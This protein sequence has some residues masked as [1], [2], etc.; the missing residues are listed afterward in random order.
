MSVH[1]SQPSYGPTTLAIATIAVLAS[2][3]L[4]RSTI[5]P[6][7]A[8][9]AMSVALG[10]VITVSAVR[11]GGLETKDL[12][13]SSRSLDSGIRY[14]LAA[15]ALVALA[16][17]GTAMVPAGRDL[18]D[19]DDA[20]VS[21]GALALRVALIIPIGTVIV[22]ELIFRG[23]LHAL[24]SEALSPSRAWIAGSVFFGLWHVF[25]SWR[26]DG[27]LM[28]TAT[29]FATSVAGAVFIWLRVRSDSLIAPCIAHL[30]T[31]TVP[32]TVAWVL[33]R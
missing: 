17:A 24:L 10:L 23:V 8:H 2:V 9:F 32:L 1:R 30:A 7:R 33:V 12:G 15:F 22:E 28:A 13:L 29:F 6:G 14:G 16:A 25:P 5:V 31:N 27:A 26:A 11:F 21:A 4:A 19:V 20:Y 3:N 18:L